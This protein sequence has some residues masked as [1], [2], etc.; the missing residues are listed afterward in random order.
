VTH[1]GALHIEDVLTRR[2]RFNIE[3]RDRGIEAAAVVGK[4]MGKLLGWNAAAEKA[5]VK[6]YRLGI[7]AE[8][9]AEQQTTDE[10]A[11]AIRTAVPSITE[12][13]A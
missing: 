10:A 11:N 13:P 8:F 3:T 1:E 6:N 2:T 9:A 7:E 5:E 12:M 4:I